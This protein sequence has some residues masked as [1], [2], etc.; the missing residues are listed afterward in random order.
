MQYKLRIDE[1]CMVTGAEC[2][3]EEAKNWK[4]KI[5]ESEQKGDNSLGAFR[6]SKK[7][8]QY[9]SFHGKIHI[10]LWNQ[11]AVAEFIVEKL[12]LSSGILQE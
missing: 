1:S 7:H 5:L 2:E 10:M 3:K 11:Y 12:R 6:G 4:K 9:C 8:Q